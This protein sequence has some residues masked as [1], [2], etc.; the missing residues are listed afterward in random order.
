MSRLPAFEHEEATIA[1]FGS[2]MATGA[3]T[4]RA[5]TQAYLER[6]EAVDARLG[7]VLET[8]PD[9]LEIADALDAERRSTGPRGP[10]H[11]IPVL[12]KDNVDT[13]DRMKT[14]AGSFALGDATPVRDAFLVRRLREAGA[15]VLG[16]AS[17]SEWANFRSTR[18]SSGWSARGGQC[19]N[20]YALDRSPCGSSSGSG[21]AVAANLCAVAVGTET[22]GS[23]VCPASVNGIVG[24]KPT[25][26]L[27]S[28]SG[29]IPVALAG[30]RGTDGEDRLRRRGAAF[31][32]R[33][34]GRRRRRHDRRADRGGL[35]G[36]RRHGRA[37]GGEDR[38]GAAPRG[39]Q[40]PAWI[41]CSTTRSTSC[42]RSAPS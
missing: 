4:S 31:G 40:R 21:V 17:L 41:A 3:L 35:H 14:T 28:R 16:K 33:R 20:P 9:A 7:S 2:A 29:V 8:N 15:V 18:S 26:G 10:L 36:V 5:I 37:P 13:A 1:E 39:V 38:R 24:I 12:V 6:I 27:V 11:G 34:R 25:V 42:G 32:A 23:I 22:D 19:R 30:H